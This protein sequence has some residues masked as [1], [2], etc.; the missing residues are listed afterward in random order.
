[1]LVLSRKKT[2]AIT[3]YTSDGPIT[4]RVVRGEQVRLGIEA[5]RHIRIC[6]EEIEPHNE[7]TEPAP[8]AA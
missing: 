6:R 2:E 8:I 4:V 3:L 7:N 5:P 1:M